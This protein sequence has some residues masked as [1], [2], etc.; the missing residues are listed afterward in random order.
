MIT[1]EGTVHEISNFYTS[2]FAF[3]M[4]KATKIIHQE[5]IW[6]REKDHLNRW[7]DLK[8]HI[9]YFDNIDLTNFTWI[10]IFLKYQQH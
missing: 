10:K 5:A 9:I 2:L 7:G 8:S 3:K 6:N 1:F 4:Y